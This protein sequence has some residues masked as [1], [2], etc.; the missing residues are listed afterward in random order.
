M[1]GIHFSSIFYPDEVIFLNHP[2]FPVVTRNIVERRGEKPVINIPIFVDSKTPVPFLDPLIGA[3]EPSPYDYASRKSN[4]IYMDSM[5]FGPSCCCL[6]MTFQT[7]TLMETLKLS[8][9]LIPICPIILALTAATPI[10]KG[11]LS[12]QDCR[13]ST[14]RAG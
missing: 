8:D 4:C 3:V 7:E 10:F 1:H 5:P 12:D 11:Y 6:Q 13:W 9:Q 14:L 2:H